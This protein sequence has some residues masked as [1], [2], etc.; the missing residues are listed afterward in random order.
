MGKELAVPEGASR[1]STGSKRSSRGDETPG[2]SA[3]GP[4][5]S[6]PRSQWT[7]RTWMIVHP[8]PS[9]GLP[10]GPR[11]QDHQSFRPVEI[12]LHAATHRLTVPA[13]DGSAHLAFETRDVSA[14]HRQS[15]PALS[16]RDGSLLRCCNT[17]LQLLQP[18][19]PLPSNPLKKILWPVRSSKP[20]GL[21]V[22]RPP[23]APAR[24]VHKAVFGASNVHESG[25]GAGRQHSCSFTVAQSDTL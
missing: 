16:R 2:W 14:A 7:S 24:T 4:S 21:Q 18:S 5:V 1:V 25:L 9:H 3:R 17:A 12:D 20:M 22:R 10:D 23:A 11:P 15:T 8:A 13:A 6:R 19:P